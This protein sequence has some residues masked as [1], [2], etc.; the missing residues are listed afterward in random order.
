MLAD[1]QLEKWKADLSAA[2]LA[3]AELE[4]LKKGIENLKK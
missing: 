1:K 4:R 2:A 3:M